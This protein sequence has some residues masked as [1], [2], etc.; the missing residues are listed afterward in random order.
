MTHILEIYFGADCI[1]QR[2]YLP[3]TLIV[4]DVGEQVYLR[5]ENPSFSEEHGPWWIVKAKKHLL[6][7]VEEGQTV[8]LLCEPDPKRGCWP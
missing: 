6:I 7:S 8:Q 5:F 2:H 1:E 3:G 4:P